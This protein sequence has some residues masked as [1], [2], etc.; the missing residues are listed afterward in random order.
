MPEVMLVESL[1]SWPVEILIGH[2]MLSGEEA[3]AG[4][5]FSWSREVCI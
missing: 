2:G 5:D 4:T 3:M 1:Q